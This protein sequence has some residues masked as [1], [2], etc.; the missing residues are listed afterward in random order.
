LTCRFGVSRQVVPASPMLALTR[1][2]EIDLS[3]GYSP[4]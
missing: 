3:F 1:G 2:Q 4:N